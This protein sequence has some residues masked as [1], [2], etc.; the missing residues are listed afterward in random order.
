M[1][2][3]DL[4]LQPLRVG[5]TATM[6]FNAVAVAPVESFTFDRCHVV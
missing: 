5:P 4:G 6:W 2:S 3:L 1:I